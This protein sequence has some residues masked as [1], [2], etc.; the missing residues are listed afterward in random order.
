M[1]EHQV[2][3][4]HRHPSSKESQ[5]LVPAALPGG[6]GCPHSTLSPVF[7]AL[8]SAH[9]PPRSYL[10]DTVHPATGQTALPHPGSWLAACCPSLR[11][12]VLPLLL[13]KGCP[14]YQVHLDAPYF[15]GL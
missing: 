1:G 14:S 2:Q 4:Q 10:E 13:A 7:R 12:P 6:T 8:C 15:W 11:T 3:K 5:S 9:A